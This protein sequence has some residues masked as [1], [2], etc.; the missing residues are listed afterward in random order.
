MSITLDYGSWLGDEGDTT[1]SATSREPSPARYHL[2]QRSEYGQNSSYTS[3]GRD[4]TTLEIARLFSD[5]D[6][7]VPDQDLLTAE[8]NAAS[9]AR[10]SDNF[11][12]P[13]PNLP[14]GSQGT[15]HISGATDTDD[16]PVIDLTDSPPQASTRPTTTTTPWRTSSPTR[17]LQH[18]TMPPTLRSQAQSRRSPQASSPP[19]HTDERPTKR[20]RIHER[21]PETSPA[22]QQPQPVRND[23]IQEVEAVDLTEV[24]DESDLSKA[25]SKQ[26]QDA[27][28][29][30]MKQTQGD[31]PPGRTPLS[32][33]KCPICMDTP[34]D[35][36]ST[37][38]GHL[39]CHKCIL[40]TLRFSAQQ[41]RDE[42]ATTNNSKSKGTCPVCRKP[43]ARKDEP[44]TG[45]TLVPLEIKLST[46]RD[47]KGKGV[48]GRNGNDGTSA[49]PGRARMQTKTERESSADMWRDLTTLEHG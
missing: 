1:D 20:Q 15:N 29:S 34:E 43:L 16:S 14:R 25:I 44:G 38:C 2:D 31:D 22:V 7:T 48:V 49:M 10:I 23:S 21:P 27:V 33:Y 28:Q 42:A 11:S 46:K 32:S 26:Q 4:P 40:D 8:M 47:L 12:H 35:A 45:R 6:E 36:T 30:Q 41:R 19:H 24:N 13:P 18:P 17:S 37:V 3:R 39:F 9:S 5:S